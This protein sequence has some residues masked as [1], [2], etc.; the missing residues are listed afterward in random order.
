MQ[1]TEDRQAEGADGCHRNDGG[2]DSN[3]WRYPSDEHDEDEQHDVGA[4]ARQ[5]GEDAADEG[6]AQHDQLR[7]G[8]PVRDKFVL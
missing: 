5:G 3:L 2:R 7:T 8:S 4:R 6:E 1:E